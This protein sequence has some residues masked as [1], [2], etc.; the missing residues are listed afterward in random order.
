MTEEYAEFYDEYDD[1]VEA[2]ANKPCCGSCA[3]HAS[4]DDSQGRVHWRSGC[5]SREEIGCEGILITEVTTPS[6][7]RARLTKNTPKDWWRKVA[8]SPVV[9]AKNS[10]AASASVGRHYGDGD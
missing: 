5:G 3:E 9:K 2:D 4:E 6:L 1:V 10:S 7:C 8:S